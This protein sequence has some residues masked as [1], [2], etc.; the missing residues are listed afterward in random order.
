MNDSAVPNWE[1]QASIPPLSPGEIHLWLLALEESGCHR[2]WLSAQEE[3]RLSG[4]PDPDMRRHYCA[5]RSLLRHLLASHLDCEPAQA[6]IR[7]APGGKPRL[8]AGPLHFNLSHAGAWLLIA[9]ARD[10]AVGVD[11]EIIRPLQHRQQIARRLFDPAETEY[12]ARTGYGERAFFTCWTRHEARQKCLGEGV[13]GE[14]A[15]PDRFPSL[16]FPITHDTTAALAWDARPD[17]PVIR[18]F[19]A[20]PDWLNPR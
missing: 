6:P 10:T 12:L 3:Q 2:Q 20:G 13:F 18:A 16:T 14:R 19:R 4:M 7:I 8:A 5:T 15:D 17:R 11:L 9:L 1:M